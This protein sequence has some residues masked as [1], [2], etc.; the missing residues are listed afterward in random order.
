MPKPQYKGLMHVIKATE[1]SLK[2]L[3][4]AWLHES[5]FRQ[6]CII[7][8]VLLPCAFL[9]GETLVQTALLIGVCVIVLI[10]ELLNSALEAAV[11]RMG[12]EFHDLA[13]RAKDMGS[14][15]VALSLALVWLTWGLVA[16]QRFVVS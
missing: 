6:E 1:Y 10:T 15:A 14:A 7:G 11:D 9:L 4:S 16:I 3:R 5:A 2:G 8:L 12:E 13:G